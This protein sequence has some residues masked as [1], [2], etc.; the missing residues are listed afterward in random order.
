MAAMILING[1]NYLTFIKIYDIII[2]GRRGIIMDNF[3]IFSQVE[4]FADSWN[5]LTFEEQAL[6]YEEIANMEAE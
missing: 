3:S 6:I 1:I 4:D 2:I 5:E